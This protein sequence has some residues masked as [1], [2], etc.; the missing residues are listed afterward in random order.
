MAWCF[1]ILQEQCIITP[2]VVVIIMVVQLFETFFRIKND[3]KRQNSIVIGCY[4]VT[5]MSYND[6]KIVLYWCFPVIYQNLGKKNT[7]KV[8]K[9][10]QEQY[11]NGCYNF[12]FTTR[13]CSQNNNKDITYFTSHKMQGRVRGRDIKKIYIYIYIQR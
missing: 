2:F 3:H 8:L 4:T 10:D 9:A 6:T 7:I 12:N 1:Y 5:C 13:T 11:F